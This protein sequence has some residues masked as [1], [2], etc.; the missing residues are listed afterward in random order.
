[1]PS[2][3]RS[4]AVIVNVVTSSLPI[5]A[6]GDTR[7]SPPHENITRVKTSAFQRHLHVSD[8]PSAVEN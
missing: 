8:R 6:L 3:P 4:A 7:V 1:M 5:E 2:L